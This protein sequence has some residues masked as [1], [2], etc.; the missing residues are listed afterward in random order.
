LREGC[1]EHMARNVL[2]P[3]APSPGCLDGTFQNFPSLQRRFAEIQHSFL[4]LLGA[5]R[6]LMVIDDDAENN[7]NYVAKRLGMANI[8]T[9]LIDWHLRESGGRGVLIDLRRDW[10]EI[11]IPLYLEHGVPVHYI[12]SPTLQGDPRFRSLSP[13]VVQATSLHND[14]N[15]AYPS[16]PTP[17]ITDHASDQFLQLRYPPDCPN[18][19][20]PG[21][22]KLKL[23][24]RVV[25]FEG[26]RPRGITNEMRKRYTE[27]IW[28]AEANGVS[29]EG[30]PFR[31]R[32]YY[33]NRPRHNLYDKYNYLYA[34]AMEN[35]SVLRKLWKFSCCPQ[36][37]FRFVPPLSEV[38]EPVGDS[39]I[40]EDVPAFSL[41]P[42]P[43][44]PTP[45]SGDPYADLED[46]D[47]MEVHFTGPPVLQPQPYV[48][49][50]ILV[51]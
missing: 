49:P 36:P 14:A 12:W 31:H 4:D 26:W 47:G 21:A 15:W 46:D 37:Y 32:I 20:S 50:F 30:H 33:R 40:P 5:L 16:S 8:E 10:M 13:P 38:C 24:H 3:E 2:F 41:R 28:F 18:S 17:L 7:L 29:T 51:I 25:D 45:S 22:P 23:V 39:T 43:A 11:N 44:A 42:V 27:D 19:V 48:H 1:V 34:P 6:W 9:H 35:L